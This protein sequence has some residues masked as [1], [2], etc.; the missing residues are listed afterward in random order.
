MT[1]IN[2]NYN[3]LSTLVLGCG[4][5]YF[6]IWSNMLIFPMVMIINISCYALSEYSVKN[7]L[8]NNMF[9]QPF[10]FYNFCATMIDAYV[11]V[12]NIEIGNKNIIKK[13][14][15]YQNIVDILY[16][17][18]SMLSGLST[19]VYCKNQL[20]IVR[21][22]FETVLLIIVDSILNQSM[23]FSQKVVTQHVLPSI[24]GKGGPMGMMSMMMSMKPPPPKNIVINESN[25]FNASN[26]RNRSLI[27]A[28]LQINQDFLNESSDESSN[29]PIDEFL[30]SQINEPI[31]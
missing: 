8:D 25:I 5:I 13:M 18:D 15:V 30:N 31:D 4:F 28:N 23:A 21:I 1:V 19:Y 2:I 26:I 12:D 6:W 22:Q 27:N 24:V 20:Q 11:F 17:F 3:K 14:S 9:L 10:H 16:Y 7:P 29:E